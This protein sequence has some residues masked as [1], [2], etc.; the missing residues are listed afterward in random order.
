MSHVEPSA[1]PA[2]DVPRWDLFISYST[3]DHRQVSYV[4]E[5]LT[6]LG[7]SIWQD[8][9]EIMYAERIREKIHEGI[10]HSSL[11]LIFISP[12]SLQS[13]WVLN[14]LDTAM[15]REISEDKPFVVPVLMGNVN[16]EDLP[17]DLRGKRYVDLRQGFRRKYQTARVGLVAAIQGA[18]IGAGIPVSRSEMPVGDDLAQFF[19]RYNYSMAGEN[20][21]ISVKDI[22][23]LAHHLATTYVE[24]YIEEGRGENGEE[25]YALQFD[26]RYG[27]FT[28]E[29]IMQYCMNE[30]E[31]SW[32]SGVGEEA[33]G[34]IFDT[35]DVI[36]KMFEL[37]WKMDR[38]KHAPIRMFAGTNADGR[39]Y[40]VGRPLAPG[41]FDPRPDWP[42]SSSTS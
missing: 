19:V 7:F 28:L 16:L 33:I 23:R 36:V 32:T 21:E 1:I 9:S 14:E 6:A 17:G 13:R 12:R 40:F 18:S 27:L 10:A 15:M 37:Q 4:I 24:S 25:E 41:E 38:D 42:P 3:R 5:D 22:A 30:C 26:K 2:R 31:I 11:V 20:S 39:I 8:Q 29:K 34:N 35:A